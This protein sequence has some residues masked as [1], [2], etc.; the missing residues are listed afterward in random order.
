VKARHIAS[1][2]AAIFFVASSAIAGGQWNLMIPPLVNAPYKVATEAPMSQWQVYRTFSSEQECDK[3]QSA[4]Q[5]KYQPTSDA[6]LGTI[7]KGTR[8]F[9][10]QMAFAQCIASDDPT[11]LR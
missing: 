7:K 2:V 3:F 8:A 4:A 10:R 5:A 1:G 9:A 11:L 6:P